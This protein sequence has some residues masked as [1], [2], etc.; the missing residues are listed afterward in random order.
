[1]TIESN[2]ELPPVASK[3]YPLPLIINTYIIN[4]KGGNYK[5]AIGQ[6]NQKKMCPCDTPII[7]VPRKSKPG[8]PLAET[9]K[10]VIDY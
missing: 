5:F 8:A 2:P 10:L 4:F 6:I 3:S 1:M 9:K 7:V